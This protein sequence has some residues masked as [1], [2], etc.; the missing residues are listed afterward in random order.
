VK[1]RER[2]SEQEARADLCEVP[3]PGVGAIECATA[4]QDV[5]LDKFPH[6]NDPPVGKGRLK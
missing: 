5:E 3:V 2:A 4:L 6:H 1:T